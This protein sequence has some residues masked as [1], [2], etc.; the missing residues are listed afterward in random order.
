[1]IVVAIWFRTRILAQFREVRKRNSK[2]TGA[3]SENVNGV[4]VV[5]ALVVSSQ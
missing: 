4:R 2:L 1:M 5:K 3:Y